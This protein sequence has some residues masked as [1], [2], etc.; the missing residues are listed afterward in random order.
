MWYTS[1]LSSKM[2]IIIIGNAYSDKA[3]IICVVPQDSILGPPAFLLYINDMPQAVD[4][5][6][7]S[8]ANNT[9][10]VFQHKDTK[11]IEEHLNLN[12]STI[13]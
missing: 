3:S 10:L 6:F 2:F 12:F 5:E 8:Y 9:V 7:L 1:H 13:S 11:T 4:S